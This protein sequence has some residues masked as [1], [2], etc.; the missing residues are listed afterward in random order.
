MIALDT[1][2]LVRFVAQDDPDQGRLVTELFQGLTAEDPAFICRETV[3][4][5]VWVLG[6]TYGY[7]RSDIARV[8]EMLLASRELE[9][10]N[11]DALG[12]I[13]GLYEARGFDFADLM[14]RQISH[15]RRAASLVTFDRRAAQLDG[16]DLLGSAEFA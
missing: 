6:E 5:L 12:A 7:S 4:E 10:E 9:V 16:V 13:V 14:I 3:L 8:L 11:S 1:N 15:A 2:V